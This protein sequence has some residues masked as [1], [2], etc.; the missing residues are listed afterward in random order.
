MPTPLPYRH[1]T[2]AVTCVSALIVLA[3]FVLAGDD[4]DTNP[5]LVRDVVRLDISAL[6][7]SSGLAVSNVNAKRFWTHND[8]GDKARLYAFDE[9]GKATGQCELNGIKAGD[10]EDMGAFVQDGQPRLIIADTGNNLGKRKSVW[11]H[12][13]D[14]PDPN[15]TTLVKQIQSIQVTFPDRAYDCEAVAVDVSRKKI[16]LVTK[17]KLPLASVFQIDLPAPL[18]ENKKTK[19]SQRSAERSTAQPI[20]T[21]TLPMVTGV[22]IDSENGDIWIINYFNAYQFPKTGNDQTLTAQLTQLPR[23]VPLPHWKQI[24]AVAVNPE[25]Q[26]WITSEGESAPLGRL[27][28]D[29]SIETERRD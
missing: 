4:V 24:E 1:L 21:L 16:L 9:R 19:R 10:W 27:Y 12:L 15:Q 17:S 6:T 26:V 14:E 23:L 28:L 11:L 5:Q 25:H 20:R 2:P 8:S 3:G 29:A 22:D 18:G 13:L 7:E